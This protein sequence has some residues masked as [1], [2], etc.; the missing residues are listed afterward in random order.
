MNRHL[1]FL[2]MGIFGVLTSCGE[3]EAIGDQSEVL[4]IVDSNFR[5]YLL[6]HEDI[7]TNGDSEIEVSEAK[8]YEGGIIVANMEISSL[9]G[10][11]HFINITNLQAFNNKLTS[12]DLSANTELVQ[13]LLE[14]NELTTLD[15]SGLSKLEDLK[16]HSNSLVSVY[17]ATGGNA[18]MWRV[19]LQGN[20]DLACI[21][22]DN[23]DV[24]DPSSWLK[25][26]GA[27]YSVNCDG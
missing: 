25:D 9:E 1:L 11:E 8:A 16:A 7:N 10:I 4:N 27:V 14:S 12:V 26:D 6:S 24:I 3:D 2:L 23:L 18:K 22:V 5:S 17:M 20:P 19:Q 13:V 15:V 21:E